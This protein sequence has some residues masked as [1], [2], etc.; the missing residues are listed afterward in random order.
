M[1][2]LFE[3]D[4]ESLKIEIQYDNDTSEYAVTVRYPDGREQIEQFTEGDEFGLWLQ[5]FER[6][7]ERQHWTRHDGP[8]IMPYAWLNKRLS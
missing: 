6:N 1:L 7:L 3:R 2:W 8:V 5:T 4:G